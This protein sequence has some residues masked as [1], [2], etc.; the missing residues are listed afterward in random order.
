ME[1][2][3]YTTTIENLKTTLE[4]YGVAVIPN[5][6]TKDEIE[7]MKTGMWDMLETITS[8][9]KTPIKRTKKKSW[10]SFYD[11]LPLHSMLLQHWQV[12]HAQFVWDLRQNPSVIKPFATL[13]NCKPDDLLV[14]F[15]GLSIHFPPE[16]TNKG[17]YNGK[18]WLHTDQ[19]YT[20]NNFECIQSFVTAYDVNEGDATLTILEGSHKYHEDFKK[21]FN[22]TDTNDWYKL[23]NE[24]EYEFYYKKGCKKFNVKCSA[25][26]M[27]FWDSR[28]I[29]AGVEPQQ[30]RK[31][32]NTRLVVY[33]CMTPR[34][35][36]NG[37]MLENKKQA[38]NDQRMTSHWPHR[39][40]LFPINPRTYGKSLPKTSNLPKPNLSDLGKKLAGF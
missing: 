22:K 24:Q 12:G 21:E 8:K 16:D 2:K 30:N 28:T 15:D 6:L 31:E 33:I 34:N 18:D 11:L 23:A 35:L 1:Y 27:V 26:S 37:S 10:E 17:W 29:H 40:K 5:I 4:Q 36:A 3:E 9:F 13:W 32:K 20:R 14:S 25:G 19:S 39:I 7:A 38:F